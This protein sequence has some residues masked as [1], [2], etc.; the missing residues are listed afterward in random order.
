[1]VRCLALADELRDV[2]GCKVAFAMVKATAGC[3]MA[4]SRGYQVLT[5][6]REALSRDYAG[7][8][9]T[10]VGEV[11]AE[12]LILDI[13]DDLPINAVS[14]LNEKGIVIATIDDP[15]ERRLLADLAFYPPVPQVLR[16]DWTGFSGKLYSGWKWVILRREFSHPIRRERHENPVILVT[17]GGSDPYGLTLKAVKALDMLDGDF[18][19]LVL[20]G[21]GFLRQDELNGIV[22]KARHKFHL[23]SGVKNIP[24]LM[25]QA[26]IALGS[27]GVTAYEL[28][29]MGVPGI[30]MCLTQDHVESASFFVESGMGECV[31]LHDH[32]SAEMLSSAIR[33]LMKNRSRWEEMSTACTKHVDGRGARRVADKIIGR[34]AN[35]D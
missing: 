2:H 11:K 21:P 12:A 26:D 23:L 6:D 33:R 29:A 16:M 22:S 30:F 4:K 20:L 34:I 25:S 9:S 24:D 31:G 15:S 3:S 5:A 1:M 27:F 10:S 13:R 35:G 8:L 17:M 18:E 14:A 32:V 19:S 7:W 28:A